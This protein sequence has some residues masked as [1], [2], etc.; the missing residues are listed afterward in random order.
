MKN[1]KKILL[2]VVAAM[3]LVVMSV[4]GTLAYLTSTSQEVKNTFT[5]GNVSIILDEAQIIDDGTKSN[6]DVRVLENSYKLQPGLTYK[7]DPT[8]TVLKGSE[9]CYVRAQVTVSDY[10]KLKDA[11][12]VDRYA[13]YWVG[14]VFLLEM[15]VNGTWDKATWIPQAVTAEKTDTSVT[16]EFW[17]KEI[18]TSEQTKDGNKVLDDLFEEIKL[19]DDMTNTELSYLKDMKINVVAHAIQAEGFDDAA[20]AWATWKDA[21]VE[22]AKPTT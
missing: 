12:P 16:Y 19:P 5:V 2:T 18:V 20:D 3:L 1:M 15:L 7:K 9:D 11:F 17:Y 13:D 21:T 8:V 22:A 6:H 10:S 14:D 4:A